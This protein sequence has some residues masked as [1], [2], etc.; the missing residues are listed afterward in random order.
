MIKM[1]NFCGDR[2][3]DT[4]CAFALVLFHSSLFNL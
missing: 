4:I 2:G 1:E 3:E